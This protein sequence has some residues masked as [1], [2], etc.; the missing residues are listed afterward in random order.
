MALTE[1]ARQPGGGLV[2]IPDVFT[3]EHRA[4]IFSIVARN[5]L[6]AIHSYSLDSPFHGLMAYVTDKKDVMQRAAGYVDRILRGAN[7]S[8]LP[9]QRPTRFN[10]IINRAAAADLGLMIPPQLSVFANEVIE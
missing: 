7:P 4:L 10:L 6:P 8:E 2:L 3:A 9:V 5:R 1:L